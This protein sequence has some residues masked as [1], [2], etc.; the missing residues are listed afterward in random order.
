M[1]HGRLVRPKIREIY[2]LMPFRANN[3]PNA[4]WACEALQ[5]LVAPAIGGDFPG[6]G[7]K[8]EHD[9]VLKYSQKLSTTRS[10]FMK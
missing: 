8:I 5:E 4:R 9:D 7:T 1:N 10:N 2:E 3:V 6:K